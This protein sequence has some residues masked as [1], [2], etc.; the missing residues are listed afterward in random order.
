VSG[1]APTEAAREW[2][3]I[4]ENDRS[5]FGTTTLRTKDAARTIRELVEYAEGL[6]EQLRIE[7]DEGLTVEQIMTGPVKLSKIGGVNLKLLQEREEA[8]Q[9]AAAQRD[10]VAAL[11]EHLRLAPVS[12]GSE[13]PTLGW[14]VAYENWL[15]AGDE[16]FAAAVVSGTPEHDENCWIACPHSEPPE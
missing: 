4:L 2:L 6:R 12:P 9:L 14:R 10:V 15:R 13:S 7:Q 16:L 5:P 1:Q 11:E 3:R 8:K